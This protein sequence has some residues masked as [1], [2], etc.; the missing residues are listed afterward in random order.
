MPSIMSIRSS[1][2]VGILI[3]AALLAACGQLAL[4]APAT[5]QAPLSPTLAPP[6]P[7]PIPLAAVV[8]GQPIRLVDYLQEIAR[9]EAAQSTAGTELAT[10]EEYQ[11]QILEA[12]VDRLLLAQGA[13]ARGIVME[14]DTLNARVEELAA[15]LGGNEAFSAW[16]SEVG[17]SLEDFRSALAEEM[18]AAAMVDQITAA[19]PETAEQVHARHILTGTREEAEWLRGQ[20]AVG[21]DFALLAS[22]YSLDPSTSLDGGDLGWFPRGY[23]LMAEV[24]E[25][26]FALQ[27]GEISAIVESPLGFHIVQSIE[28]TERPLEPDAMLKAR[29]QAVKVWLTSQREAANIQILIAQ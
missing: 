1:L 20:L 23:L 5:S 12:L 4:P 15:D 2:L 19:V 26:A 18:L 22:L 10:L 21:G 16:L 6:T 11:S 14:Q 24:E 9:F 28:R 13:Q 25:A 27:P 29:E 7:T 8:N 17:Y 3:H